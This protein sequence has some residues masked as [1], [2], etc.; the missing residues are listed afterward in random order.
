MVNSHQIVDVSA[1]YIDD[2]KMAKTPFSQSPRRRIGT[3][4]PR[5][6]IS[7][8]DILFC[9]ALYFGDVWL[10]TNVV[11]KNENQT[12]VL[13]PDVNIGTL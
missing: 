13:P 6:L 5:V 12:F 8:C 3:F 9:N 2:R 4:L 10:L 11:K 7:S 1:Y